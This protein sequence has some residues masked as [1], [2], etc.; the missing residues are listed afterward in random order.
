MSVLNNIGDANLEFDLV[1][2]NDP[3][4]QFSFCEIGKLSAAFFFSSSRKWLPSIRKLSQGKLDR[5]HHFEAGSSSLGGGSSNTKS[6]VLHKQFS[7]N[8]FKVGKK[9][10]III[11]Q[12]HILVL[13]QRLAFSIELAPRDI[14]GFSSRI[15]LCKSITSLIQRE[16][17]SGKETDGFLFLLRHILLL[18]SGTFCQ[19]REN[20]EKQD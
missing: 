1:A 19:R 12:K 15:V 13:H 6:S 16:R 7:K 14:S 10:I 18:G 20:W 8:K 11:I 3:I 5:N 17:N 2:N 9:T 4:F